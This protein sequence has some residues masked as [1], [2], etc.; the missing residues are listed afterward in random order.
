MISDSVSKTIS[1]LRFPLIILVVF[2]HVP[3]L[4]GGGEIYSYVTTLLSVKVASI[5]VPCFFLI[6]GL[7]FFDTSF[8][9]KKYILKLRKR[10]VTLL[11]PYILWNAFFFIYYNNTEFT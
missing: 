3:R 10:I 2:I 1:F 4:P 5:A 6:S 8:N 9:F 7:L 11:I